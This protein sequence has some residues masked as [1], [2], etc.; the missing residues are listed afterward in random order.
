MFKINILYAFIA[1]VAAPVMA[2][3][4]LSETGEFLDGVAAIVNEGVVLKSQFD[5]QM[6]TV[7]ERASQQ[8]MQLP[9]TNVLE[10][11]I[12]ERLI[13]NEIQLQRA[14]R[15]GLVQ[16]SDAALNDA[17]RRIAEQNGG[18]IRGYA[19]PA[20]RR[21]ASITRTFA[22]PCVTRLQ[23][24]N[25]VVSRSARASIVSD[26]EIE[27]CILDLET[28]V[29]VNSD[30]ELSHILLPFNAS[31]RRATDRAEAEQLANEI[32]ARVA[33]R[34]GFSRTCRALLKGP[35]CT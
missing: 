16:I 22:E 32:Y 9:P 14:E 17:I 12:L 13:L 25:C 34:R 20:C 15:I 3:D 30:W 28:N 26:R 11:Q 23:S 6:K 2:A 10:E 18:Q 31:L 29:V 5:E 4:E 27:Q 35:Y 7:T 24:N 33:G 19:C 1:L 21:T 8:G